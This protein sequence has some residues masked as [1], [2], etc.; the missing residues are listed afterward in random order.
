MFHCF[1]LFVGEPA[2]VWVQEGEGLK[3]DE[4]SRFVSLFLSLSQ[5]PKF[6]V[7]PEV[8]IPLEQCNKT[9]IPYAKL[10]INVVC[11]LTKSGGI[12]RT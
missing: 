11:F 6:S 9:E 12:N 2:C 4:F 10:L 8:F 5:C 3:K 7:N 1:R